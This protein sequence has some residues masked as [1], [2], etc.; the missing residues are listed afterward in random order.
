[1]VVANLAQRP[2]SIAT[3]RTEAVRS[4]VAEGQ[5]LLKLCPWLGLLYRRTG[6]V[7]RDL[8]QIVNLLEC[9]EEE[10]GMGYPRFLI[11]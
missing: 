3:A 1:M 2:A 4:F 9:A 5:A 10:A 6:V 8:I 7:G 11:D